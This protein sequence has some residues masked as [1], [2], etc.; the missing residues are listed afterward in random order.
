MMLCYHYEE[1]FDLMDPLKGCQ[2]PEGSPDL[3]LR[4]TSL[5]ALILFNIYKTLIGT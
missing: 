4:T 3:T 1:S 5:N 2:G